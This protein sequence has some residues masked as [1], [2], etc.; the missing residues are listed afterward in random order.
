MICGAIPTLFILPNE[1][2][3]WGLLIYIGPTTGK[4]VV[5]SKATVLWLN[6]WIKDCY[7]RAHASSTLMYYIDIL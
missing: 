2:T 1:N 4:R 6:R 5:L 7:A 3:I